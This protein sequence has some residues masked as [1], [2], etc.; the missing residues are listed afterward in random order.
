[1]IP[2]PSKKIISIGNKSFLKLIFF[3][4]L[5]HIK[6]QRK[7][8]VAKA[9]SPKIKDMDLLSLF[10]LTPKYILN[11]YLLANNSSYQFKKLFFTGLNYTNLNY[12]ALLSFRFLT[13]LSSRDNKKFL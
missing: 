7:A 6:V 5:L 13:K 1:M 11:F 4:Q 12:Y 10:M 8:M 3:N 2:N 9:L